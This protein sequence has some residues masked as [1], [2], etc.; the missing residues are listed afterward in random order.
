MADQH[1]VED[2][3]PPGSTPAAPEPQRCTPIPS[4]APLARQI[5]NAGWDAG[6][7]SALRNLQRM[8]DAF[9]HLPSSEALTAMRGAF[10]AM[11]KKE[12]TPT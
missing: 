5:S 4:I 8:V 10:D 7:E 6:Y 12:N 2:Y 1:G 11:K 3:F 9:P